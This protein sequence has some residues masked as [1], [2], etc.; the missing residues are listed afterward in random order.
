MSRFSHAWA[1]NTVVRLPL[2]TR[3]DRHASAALGQRYI[4]VPLAQSWWLER[5]V[6]VP[7]QDVLDALAL[8]AQVPRSRC[9][10]GGCLSHRITCIT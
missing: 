9:K 3:M 7:V 4:M 8:A 1:A 2:L 6:Q 10:A 5:T